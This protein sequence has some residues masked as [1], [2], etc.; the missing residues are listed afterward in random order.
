VTQNEF[1]DLLR[2]IQTDA[3]SAEPERL[4]T[5]IDEV[6]GYDNALRSEWRTGSA[7]YELGES[8]ATLHEWVSAIDC[9][10]EALSPKDADSEVPIRALEQLANVEGRYAAQLRREAQQRE[11]KGGEKAAAAKRRELLEDAR[12]RLELALKFGETS[13]R[14]S[15][16]GSYLKRLALESDDE[17]RQQLI[18]DA[19][20]RYKQAYE[21]KYLQTQASPDP[22]PALNWIP[23]L[24]LANSPE[25]NEKQR[26]EFLEEIKKNE[27]A[28]SQRQVEQPSFWERVHAPDAALLRALIQGDLKKQADE[29]LRQYRE[30]FQTRST[31]YQRE[32]VLN[33]LDF[34]SE[35]LAWKGQ[36][37][38]AGQMSKLCSEL[39][40]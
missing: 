34:L 27:Q 4:K 26:G 18:R 5:L 23:L 21:R 3:Q 25:E 29:I 11:K 2:R 9:Y 35:M 20:A 28:A 12:K 1:L 31:A 36:A 40:K 10:T 33:Q 37:A 39:E 7:L 8:Y 24:F 13:E 14:L 6:R 19:A 17:G 30:A 32:S 15:L 16:L 38:L 22:Y